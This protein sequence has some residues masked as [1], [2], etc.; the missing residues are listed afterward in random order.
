MS[1]SSIRCKL[2]IYFQSCMFCCLYLYL[3]KHSKNASL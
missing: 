1:V 3:F 2:V